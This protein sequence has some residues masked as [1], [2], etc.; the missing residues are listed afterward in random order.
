MKLQRIPDINSEEII[1][2]VYCMIK[3]KNNLIHYKDTES[4]LTKRL[5]SFYSQ[6]ILFMKY[7]NIS[8][9]NKFT[10]KIAFER[11]N[12]G[13]SL[14]EV[15]TVFNIFQTVIWKYISHNFPQKEILSNIAII[16]TIFGELKDEIACIYVKLSENNKEKSFNTESLFE[17]TERPI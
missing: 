12:S 6:L 2:E 13:F 4:L 14:F 3:N 10:E 9:L 15:L 8:Q 16:S 7:N 5:N 1:K 17:G 11:F